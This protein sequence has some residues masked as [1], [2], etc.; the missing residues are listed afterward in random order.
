M[1]FAHSIWLLAGVAACGILAV[2]FYFFQKK[3][4]A[5]LQ[6]FA[7]GRLLE[8]THLRGFPQKTDD[9][10]GDPGAGGGFD[11][12]RP[13]AA[14]NGLSMERGQAKGY[15]YPGGSGHLKKYAGRRCEAQS[16]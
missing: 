8:K 6:E 7:S 1:Q 5:A 2:S 4:T 9:Q 3:S 13:G 12:C 16:S 10:T 11:F 14:S 15:R